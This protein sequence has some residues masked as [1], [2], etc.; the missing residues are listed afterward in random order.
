MP[1]GWQEVALKAPSYLGQVGTA[2]K[3]DRDRK[4]GSYDQRVSMAHRAV[5]AGQ[6]RDLH[7]ARKA[8]HPPGRTNQRVGTLLGTRRAAPNRIASQDLGKVLVCPFRALHPDAGGEMPEK[9]FCRSTNVKL[10]KRCTNFVCNLV[11]R[12]RTYPSGPVVQCRY[13]RGCPASVLPV[14]RWGRLCR[15]RSAPSYPRSRNLPVA[16]FSCAGGDHCAGWLESIWPCTNTGISESQPAPGQSSQQRNNRHKR[17]IRHRG[18]TGTRE[19]WQRF[20]CNWPHLTILFCPLG[21]SEG[22]YS[23]VQLC[24]QNRLSAIHS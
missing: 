3:C 16:M 15:L 19:V 23:C 17:H 4:P 6:W 11:R 12:V 5:E 22:S 14:C 1:G 7:P 9:T 8:G 13:V 20:A 10:R 21:R 24:D 2:G 18:L